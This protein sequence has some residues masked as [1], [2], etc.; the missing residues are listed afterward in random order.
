MS[1]TVSRMDRQPVFTPEKR[2]ALR[3][4]LIAAAREDSRIT[5]AAITGS[6]SV[7]NEDRWSD[8]DL[9]FGVRDAGEIESVLADF[10][11]IMY[12][13]HGALHHVDVTSGA[14]IYRVFL[15]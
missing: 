1:G 12:R 5:G 6:A 2:E 3:S 4:A 14:W 10:T 15:L 9:G 13:E 7:G 8:I 11:A